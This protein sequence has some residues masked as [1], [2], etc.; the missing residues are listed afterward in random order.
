MAAGLCVTISLTLSEGETNN[1]KGR[2]QRQNGRPRGKHRR[3]G[4]KTLRFK[5][6]YK[7]SWSRDY[8]VIFGYVPISFVNVSWIDEMTLTSKCLLHWKAVLCSWMPQC[9]WQQH[10]NHV[11]FFS[12]V[13][14]TSTWNGKKTPFRGRLWLRVRV[15]VLQPEGRQFDPQST[16]RSVLEQ[17]AERRIAPLRTT[18]CC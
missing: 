13:A 17:D 16:C 1:S 6:Q 14:N 15:V 12:A 5:S 11:V 18:K 4:E 9:Y 10:T 7:S 8:Q 2:C 3:L